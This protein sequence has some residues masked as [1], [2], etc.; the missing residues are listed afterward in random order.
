MRRLTSVAVALALVASGCDSGY[1]YRP[2]GPKGKRI[3]RWSETIEGVRFSVD[4]YNTRSDSTSGFMR[5]EIANES[6]RDVVVLGGQL[7][8]QPQ[9]T[10]S[11]TIDARVPDAPEGREERTVPPGASKSVDLFVEFGG[12][13]AVLGDVMMYS[14]RVQIGGEERVIKVF[15][16]KRF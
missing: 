13:A 2:M 5:L 4:H 15:M 7:V 11:K 8:T 12:S 1:T 3:E 10:A 14:W 16:T 9:S 6:K